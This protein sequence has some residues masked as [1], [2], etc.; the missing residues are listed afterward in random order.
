VALDHSNT[1]HQ[2]EV[3]DTEKHQNRITPRDTKADLDANTWVSTISI[4]Y[5]TGGGIPAGDL[6]PGVDLPD[7][8]HRYQISA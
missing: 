1:L 3:I 4:Y 5:K 8:L 2:H 6:K 7:Y